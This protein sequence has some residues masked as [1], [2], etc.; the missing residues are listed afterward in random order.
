MITRMR[1]RA[2]ARAKAVRGR[3]GAARRHTVT[4]STKR[5]SLDAGPKA[6][7]VGESATAA[8]VAPTADRARQLL[9][10]ELD[11]RVWHDPNGEP[12]S[13]RYKLY[14]S[15]R[16]QRQLPLLGHR[17]RIWRHNSKP[18]GYELANSLGIEV[19]I[20][21]AASVHIDEI[22]RLQL[23]D[24][25][26][27]KPHQGAA[28][29]GVFLLVR[30]GEGFLDLMDM[31]TTSID[32]VVATC[33]Q[34]A[35]SGAISERLVIEELLQPPAEIA[36]HVFVPDDLKVYCF[37][38]RPVLIMQRRMYD[39]R[40]PDHPGAPGPASWMFKFWTT[41]WED[42]GPVKF[43]DRYREA[44]ERP[45][46]GDAVLAAAA[47]M[48]STLAVPFVRLDLYDTD[49]GPVFGEVSPHP[50][51]PEVWSDEM[52]DLLGRHWELAEARLQADGVDL[53]EPI[54]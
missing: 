39:A 1:R 7:L 31:K 14:E 15:K 26:V 6:T 4:V 13:F 24:R 30:Q 25:F 29:R 46:G 33:R 23:P 52:D 2:V 3:L 17:Q 40:R 38:D 36:D 27:L 51:P 45:P 21:H 44:L 20:Q 43:S 16:R 11:E 54:R 42:L 9:P 48:S 18:D 32:G 49:R 5:H 47:R 8:F 34:L 12:P 19:P 22:Q 37:Y 53:S 10:I 50:G 35:D 41:A 28:N